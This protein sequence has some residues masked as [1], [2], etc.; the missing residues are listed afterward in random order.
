MIPLSH[1]VVR[2]FDI[3]KC[4]V[5]LNLEH[6]IEVY[7]RACFGMLGLLVPLLFFFIVALPPVEGERVVREDTMSPDAR[8]SWIDDLRSLSCLRRQNREGIEA[9]AVLCEVVGGDPRDYHL[10]I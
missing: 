8:G 7:L 5:L 3:L 9:M 4:A 2:V 1:F 6:A 10:Y